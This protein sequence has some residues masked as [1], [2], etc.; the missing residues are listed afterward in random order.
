MKQTMKRKES[1]AL[2][3]DSQG[4]TQGGSESEFDFGDSEMRDTTL[5]DG[6]DEVHYEYSYILRATENALRSSFTARELIK[7]RTQMQ[8]RMLSSRGHT[9]SASS[10]KGRTASASSQI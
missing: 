3:D 8:E 5:L 6:V 10:Q 9:A 7:R 4:L 1:L 2:G